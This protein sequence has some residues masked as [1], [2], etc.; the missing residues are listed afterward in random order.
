[1]KINISVD[2]R[3]V[4]DELHRLLDAPD[5]R[6]MTSFAEIFATMA[7]EVFALIHI[8]TGSL[9]ST[10]TWDSPAYPGGWQGT[11]KVGGAAPGMPRD[12]AYYGVF[13][14]ARG[15]THFFFAPAY[16]NIPSRIIKE[17][18]NFFS[19]SRTQ[20]LTAEAP[21]LL[22]NSKVAA[23]S[24]EKSAAY[25]KNRVQTILK[26]HL[27]KGLANPSGTSKPSSSGFYIGGA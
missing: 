25:Q 24:V 19:N 20:E 11:I 26:A 7:A 10:T 13:E 1:M 17:I 2:D 27:A 12:P 14:L 9:K 22:G 6:T 16:A 4:K 5:V 21:S 3:Q 23:R 18:I 15:G 8:E